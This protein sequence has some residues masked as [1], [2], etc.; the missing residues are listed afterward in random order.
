M[1]FF[2]PENYF[3]VR[4]TLM[5][6][7]YSD[8]IGGCEGLISPNPPKEAI[9]AR[10]KQANAAAR[11]DHYHSVA[12]PSAGQA[13]GERSDPPL[14]KNTGYS[15]GRKSAKRQQSKNR[16]KLALLVPAM[17]QTLLW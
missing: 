14:A 4:A 6:Y 7:G 10:R 16:G 5:Q 3:E 12:N 15:P 13:T 11:A 17:P 9:E 1:Q 8:L 2:K